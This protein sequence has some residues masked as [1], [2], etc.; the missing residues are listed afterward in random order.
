MKVL[1]SRHIENNKKFFYDSIKRKLD[2]NEKVYI[3]VPNQFTL[4]TEIEAYNELGIDS[5][6][7]LRIKSFKTIV[8]EILYETGKNHLNFISDN[9]KIFIL[10][11]ILLEIKSELEIFN[12]NIKDD[13]FI[14]LLIDLLDNF[15]ENDIFPEDLKNILSSEELSIE[16]KNKLKDLLIIYDKFQKFKQESKYE[17]K[18]KQDIAI[19]EVNKMNI[20]SDIS[21]YYY[22]FN[23]MKKKEIKL[24]S[25]IDK[26]AKDTY[27]NICLDDRLQKNMDRNLLEDADIFEV[28]EDFIKNLELP[29]YKNN[30]KKIFNNYPDNYKLNNIEKFLDNVFSYNLR[31]VEK[32]F[33]NNRLDKIYIR[34]SN[35]TSEEV[36]N[37]AIS[38]KKDIIDNN[39]SY[40]DIAI[41]T[42]DSSEYY[43]KIK[44]IFKLNDIPYF[45]DEDRNLLNNSM[46][47]FLLSSILMLESKFSTSSVISFLKSAFLD[48]SDEEINY[49]QSYI[50][51]R[52][53]RGMMFFEKDCFS[54]EDIENSKSKYKE[55]DLQSFEMVIKVLN[56][57]RDIV[58]SLNNLDSIISGKYELSAKEFVENIYR[59]ITNEFLIKGYEEYSKD[60]SKEELEENKIIYDNFI[61]LLDDIYN[62]SFE[63]NISFDRYSEILREVINNFR[64]GIIPPSQ[65]QI[66]I[67]D[68]LRSRFNNVKKLY[69][70]G[71]TNIYYPV[72]N[73]ILDILND[74]DKSNL[75]KLGMEFPIANIKPIANSQ[76]SFYELLYTS[77]EEIE[78]SYSLVNSENKTMEKASI[79]NWIS[80]MILEKNYKKDSYNYK[81]YIYSKTKLS[82]YLPYLY[83]NIKNKN[84]INKEELDFAN[85]LKNEIIISKNDYTFIVDSIDL[86]KKDYHKVNLNQDLVKKLY[87]TNYFSISQLQE[88]NKN[89]YDHFIKYGLKPR[90][91]LIYDVN[92]L[93]KGNILHEY[94][95]EYI[96]KKYLFN[97]NK[98]ISFE[99]IVKNNME[100]FRLEN[101]KNNF[102]LNIMY[103]NL[104]AYSKI[105]DEQIYL[106]PVNRFYLEE[107][108]SKEGVFNPIKVDLNGEEIFIEGIIDRVDEFIYD[109]QKYIRVIDY[110]SGNKK[111]DI[112]NIFYGIDL[113]IIT[114]L[115]AVLETFKDSKPFGAFYQNLNQNLYLLDINTDDM[116]LSNKNFKL[117]G[118]LSGNVIKKEEDLNFIRQFNYDGRRT[119]KNYFEPGF[120][121]TQEKLDEIA[122]KV[123]I[124][125]ET[126]YYLFNHNKKLI[127][128]TIKEILSGNISL[129]PYQ[130]KQEVG[131]E[132]SSYKIIHREDGKEYRILTPY[133]LEEI[134]SKIKEE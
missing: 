114:Y 109:G 131:D 54:K 132:Y 124:S 22:R 33:K 99:D 98:K 57:F 11:S 69:V 1:I 70:L 97:V 84:Y 41:L 101:N 83:R 66:I 40:K 121:I 5:T 118:Y 122:N 17:L 48:V 94:L 117:K 8:E 107:K 78:F 32:R 29:E 14:N 120:K 125:E 38:I 86:I 21:F 30:I 105:I 103:E 45:I 7:N 76:L 51:R 113:Q 80:L 72:E 4:G 35:N 9:T 81:E 64:V 55:E 110:K 129:S 133:K 71:M 87:R 65:D 123:G 68:L 58:S 73:K 119:P 60:I 116:I 90:E 134:I 19:N 42:T 106:K 20:Y 24:L 49:F 104:L 6:F 12:K 59:F 2:N 47:K 34:R 82:R 10:Q 95:K 67:G 25:L 115:R 75:I 61:A 92:S 26:I 91:N 111:L 102:F 44:K 93:D 62:I 15:C 130:L 128:N 108:Y 56:V 53:I 18:N 88:F 50:Q 89:P 43:E 85:S 112:N 63:K 27:I 127:K 36:E 31:D 46:V 28:S 79:I 13:G 100:K 23:Y 39:Y 16:L 3:I 77:K 52:R 37:L 96:S 74:E 126:F